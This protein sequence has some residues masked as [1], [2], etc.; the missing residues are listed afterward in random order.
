MWFVFSTPGGIRDVTH[1]CDSK[2]KAVC[3][4]IQNMM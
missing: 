1:M 2:L 4:G 3:D